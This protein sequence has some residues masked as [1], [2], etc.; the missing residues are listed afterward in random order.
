[1]FSFSKLDSSM[2]V[3]EIT[4]F[5]K[6]VSLLSYIAQVT[7]LKY[8]NSL[9]CE[10]RGGLAWLACGP[11]LE[12]VHAVTG[13][14][15]SAYCFSSGTEHPPTVLAVRDFSWLKRSGHSSPSS[16]VHDFYDKQ[17]L[18]YKLTLERYCNSLL[19]TL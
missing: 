10:G 19:L 1:M 16:P 18:Y 9:A 4:W 2:S 13:E 6:K 14:R 3:H 12:V 15:L 7:T 5:Q 8:C 11:H 17:M